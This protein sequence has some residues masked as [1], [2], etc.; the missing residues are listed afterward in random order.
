VPFI[1]HPPPLPKNYTDVHVAP[2]AATARGCHYHY[3]IALSC[4]AFGNAVYACPGSCF[5]L[6]YTVYMENHHIGKSVFSA[7]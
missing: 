3:Y 1:P 5:C 2:G 4:T 6:P 7:E